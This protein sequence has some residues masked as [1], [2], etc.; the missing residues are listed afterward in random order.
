MSLVYTQTAI[1]QAPLLPSGPGP[2]PASQT[3]LS[4]SPTPAFLATLRGLLA[5]AGFLLRLELGKCA[6]D[7]CSFSNPVHLPIHLFIL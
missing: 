2:T 7:I 3:L 4:L 1:S 6:G 5:F